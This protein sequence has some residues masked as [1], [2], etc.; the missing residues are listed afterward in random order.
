[1]ILL[2][3]SIIAYINY[4]SLYIISITFIQEKNYYVRPQKKKVKCNCGG[5]I[6]SNI[7]ILWAYYKCKKIKAIV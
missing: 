5:E 4:S 1:M 3:L 2:A 6:F 7:L